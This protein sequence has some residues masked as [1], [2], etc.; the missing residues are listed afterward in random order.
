MIKTLMKVFRKA[1]TQGVIAKYITTAN[2][3]CQ[4]LCLAHVLGEVRSEVQS[5]PV[6]KVDNKSAIGLIKNP[7]LSEQSQHIEVKLQEK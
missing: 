4:C 2:A 7:V 6:L 1:V 5:R 3:T